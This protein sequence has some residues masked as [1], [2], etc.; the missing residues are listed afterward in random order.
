M[1]K[2]YFALIVSLWPSIE[3]SSQVQIFGRASHFSMIPYE[4]RDIVVEKE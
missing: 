3:E 4:V 2:P 1:A